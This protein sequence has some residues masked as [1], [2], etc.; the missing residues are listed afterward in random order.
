MRTL[1]LEA[2]SPEAL[3]EECIE[4]GWSDGL[5]VVPPL[6][7]LVE[8]H[9]AASGQPAD[10]LI[11]EIPPAWGGATVERVAANAVMAG[12]RP[13]YVPAVI[14]ALRALLAPTVGLHGVQCTT[15]I[16]T[17]LLIFNGPVRRTLGIA[18]GHNCLGQGFRANATIGRAVRLTLTNLGG[19]RPGGM[20]KATFGHPGKFSYCFAENEEESP[21]PPYHVEAGLAPEQSAV[22]VFAAE[23]PHNVNNHASNDPHSL[24][25]TIADTMRTLGNNNM[26]LGSECIVVLG[27][28]HARVIADTGWSRRHVQFFLYERARRSVKELAMGGMYGPDVGRNLWPQWIDRANPEGLVP[29]A[30][31]PFDIKVF[32]AGGAGRHSL[33]IPGWGT[34]THTQPFEYPVRE[35]PNASL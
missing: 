33:V 30:R 2:S 25:L 22:T 32:V 11:G 12:C 18:C 27:V 24:L 35:N 7:H 5:P 1:H 8:A 31:T 13:E 26:Y 15:H 20:D 29:V 21:F 9:V 17:P 6:R 23:A 4:R 34:R 19:A 16:A 14:A 3:I 10:H 28:E